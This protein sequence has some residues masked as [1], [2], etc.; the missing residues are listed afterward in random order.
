[1]LPSYNLEIVNT[2]NYFI[3]ENAKTA[4]AHLKTMGYATISSAL[5]EEIEKHAARQNFIELLKP[6]LNGYNMGLMSDA[7]CPAVA[8][9]GADIV[10]VAHTVGIEVIPLVGPSSILLSIMASGFNGQSFAFNGY[11][12]I[13]K[14]ARQKKIKDLELIANKAQQSQFFIETPYRN[15]QMLQQLFE[16]L[17]PNTKLFI[18][19]DLTGSKTFAKS[20]T[21]EMWKKQLLP[22]LDKLPCIF[23]IYG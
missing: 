9:P 17:K 3:A 11:L 4:R 1:M 22:E 2:L 7:G 18:G 6:C 16:T 5:I 23:G 13:E 12:P 15:K 19:V 20:Y 8:D 14:S 10:T 21:I